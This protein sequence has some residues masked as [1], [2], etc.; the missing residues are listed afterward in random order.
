MEG[1][2][3]FADGGNLVGKWGERFG[4]WES[5]VG[6]VSSLAEY[7]RDFVDLEMNLVD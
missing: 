3:D 4:N 2:L 7:E 6:L 5:Y 1:K